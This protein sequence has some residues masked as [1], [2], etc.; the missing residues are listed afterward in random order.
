MSGITARRE[1]ADWHLKNH[2][3][4]GPAWA[5]CWCC[6]TLCDPDY[7]LEKSNPHWMAAVAT[8][9]KSE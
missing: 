2:G 1:A 7:G 5:E 9:P 6:C 3:V 8:L 4:R